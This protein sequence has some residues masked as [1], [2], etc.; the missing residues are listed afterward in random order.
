M[1]KGLVLPVPNS[2]HEPVPKKTEKQQSQRLYYDVLVKDVNDL[3]TAIEML[4]YSRAKAIVTQ[5]KD[6]LRLVNCS[7][8]TLQLS[9]LQLAASLPNNPNKLLIVQ[10]LIEHGARVHESDRYG[11]TALYQAASMGSHEVVRLLLEKGANPNTRCTLKVQDNKFA[12]NV[13]FEKELSLPEKFEPPKIWGR[14]PLHQC[15]RINHVPCVQLLLDKKATVNTLDSDECSPLQLAG[16]RL[17]INIRIQLQRYEAI[18]D[19]LVKSGADVNILAKGDALPPLFQSV[20]LGSVGATSLLLNAGANASTIHEKSGKNILHMAAESGKPNVI[21]QLLNYQSDMRG[22]VNVADRNGNTPL[23]QGAYLGDKDCLK[24]LI[25]NGGDLAAENEDGLSVI[26]TIYQHITRPREFLIELLDSKIICNEDK[27]KN[28]PCEVCD[29][30][31]LDFQIL[32]PL[33]NNR[34]MSVVS[35]LTCEQKLIQHPL[36]EA[37]IHV[38]WKRMRWLFF[39]IFSLHVCFVISLSVFSLLLVNPGWTHDVKNLG[40]TIRCTTR[41]VLVLSAF[42]L[43]LHSFLQLLLMGLLRYHLTEPWV[44]FICSLYGMFMAYCIDHSS[45]YRSNKM[46]ILTHIASIVIVTAWGCLMFQ[47]GR[48]PCWGNYGLMFTAVLNNVLKVMSTGVCL[49]IGFVLC[50]WIQFPSKFK[51]VWNPFIRMVIMMT[52]ELNDEFFFTYDSSSEL[53]CSRLVFVIFILLASIVLTN[54]MLGLAV[55][56]VQALQLEGHAIH[57]KKQTEFIVHLERL[58]THWVLHSRFF[59]SIIREMLNSKHHVPTKLFVK[60]IG[61]GHSE[62][63]DRIMDE[64]VPIARAKRHNKAA[65]KPV[66]DQSSSLLV[67]DDSFDLPSISTELTDVTDTK[68]PKTSYGASLHLDEMGT[69]QDSSNEMLQLLRE[70][71]QLLLIRDHDNLSQR[72]NTLTTNDDQPNVGA[73]LR[74][75]SQVKRSR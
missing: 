19:L 40:A 74:R 42:L 13:P 22:F 20:K 36:I 6:S 38:K 15:V 12:E 65:D 50:F 17:P 56:D 51:G 27:K 34:Q 55:N 63:P 71:K 4:N 23:H 30:V 69:G 45:V 58:T 31:E 44:N 66:R 39:F 10:L 29:R 41:I 43:L 47:L 37:F 11:R 59:P 52:G 21:Q 28:G 7:C 73:F 25:N 46:A 54:L 14:T 60:D 9:P 68:P 48:F 53:Q 64:I 57:L 75:L 8:G 16:I 67:T 72:S 26:Y 5:S 33:N 32:A 62:L 49:F 1:K 18:V 61:S 70:I 35:L 24:I 2:D 3:M